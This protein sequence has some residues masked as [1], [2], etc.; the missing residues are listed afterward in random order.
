MKALVRA[1]AVHRQDETVIEEIPGK[2][3]QSIGSNEHDHFLVG[4]MARALRIDMEKRFGGNFPVLHA[5][6]SWILRHSGWLLNRFCI[7]KDGYTAFPE[8]QGHDLQWRWYAI[9]SSACYSRCPLR[10]RQSWTTDSDLVF[11]SARQREGTTASIFDGDEVQKCWT[12]KRRPEHLRW[13]R[14]RVDALDTHPL[15]PRPPRER[16]QCEH[17]RRYI[18]WA[19]VKKYGGTPNC[20]ACAVDGP[21]HSKECRERFE[22]IFRKEEEEKAMM[23]AAAAAA[24]S[25]TQDESTSSTIPPTSASTSVT[26]MQV[27]HP[28]DEVMPVTGTADVDQPDAEISEAALKR[29]ETEDVPVSRKVRKITGLAV[30]SMDIVCAAQ[31]DYDAPQLLE[32]GSEQKAGGDTDAVHTYEGEPM[33]SFEVP[34]PEQDI[35]GVKSG[36]VLDP[37]KVQAA[38]QKEMDSIARDEVVELVKTSD[39]KQGAHVKGGWVEDNKGDIVRSRF[40]A[41]QV[42]CNPRDDVSQSTP[43]LLI[44]SP[45]AQ[46]CGLHRAD[47]LRHR[48]GAVHL[49]HLGGVLP[50]CDGRAGTRASSP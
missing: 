10:R 6:H 50:C 16:T 41:K 23:E 4:G 35:I 27:E 1:V 25:S 28:T 15:R 20:K 39:C 3:S 11:G 14:G 32:N 21:S 17:P 43:A 29:S 31:A 9:S 5:V 45:L 2:S 24:S 48:G 7:G 30:C 37:A 36:V 18:T 34:V 8:I 22:V 38:R 47:L 13:D 42:A 46:H 12:V 49:R 40:V 19:Y 44:L 33:K 26:P